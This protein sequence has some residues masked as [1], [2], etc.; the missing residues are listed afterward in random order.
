MPSI[1]PCS[2]QEEISEK[3]KKLAKLQAAVAATQRDARQLAQECQA[4]R[5]QLLDDIRALAKQI[6]LKASG[7]NC[8][9]D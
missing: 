9:C 7:G 1:S 8:D 6:K 4:E 3:G 2:S 5:E